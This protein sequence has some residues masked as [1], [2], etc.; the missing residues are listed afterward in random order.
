MK[1]TLGISDTFEPQR[2]NPGALL[3]K[4]F[5]GLEA[6]KAQRKRHFETEQKLSE[7]N[8]LKEEVSSIKNDLTSIKELLIK[9]LE[10]R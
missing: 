9:V 3:N 7:I 1:K 8:T 5:T 10:T 4:D 6:Y 2:N